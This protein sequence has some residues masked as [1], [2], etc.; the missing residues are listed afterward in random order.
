MRAPL[1]REPSVS[2]APGLDAWT[3]DELARSFGD[4]T[5]L[6]EPMARHTSFRIGGPAD[7]WVQVESAEELSRVAKI[8][9][10]ATVPVF[11]LGSGTNIL[12]SDRGI[13][14]VVVHL[15]PGFSF[16]EWKA[17]GDET[18][19]RA[20]AALA[21]KKVVAAAVRR[22]LT[23]LEFAEGIPGSLGGGLT[24]NAGAFGGEIGRVVLDLEGVHRDGRIET[25]PRD[26]LP[27]EYRRLDLPAGF[28]ITAVR[29]HLR[30]G[31]DDEIRERVANARGKRKK[32]QPL[33]LPNAGSIFK[34]PKGTFAGRLLEE[35]GLKGRTVGGA[36]VSDRHANFIVNAGGAT[37]ADVRALMR[38]MADVVSART[39][40][41][42]EPEIK[43]VGDFDHP[44]GVARPPE[45]VLDHPPDFVRPGVCD[46][47]AS[48]T[49]PLPKGVK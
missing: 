5:R 40:V 32:A 48:E 28:V 21:F 17:S 26:R 24:M 8:L 4:R 16:L 20:G 47:S 45:G 3:R 37:A 2:A 7:V 41:A 44:P 39:G 27:F 18:E 31:V 38:E 46:A 13:R 1:E 22:G 42:L 10:R 6:D 35:A 30:R 15:G 36:R 11:V 25:I 33:G 49:T 14:G 19:V 12:V 9:A 34:N 29:M 43:L 23:G